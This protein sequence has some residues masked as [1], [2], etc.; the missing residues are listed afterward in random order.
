MKWTPSASSTEWMVTMLGWF[1]A[2]TA[3]ASRSKRGPSFGIGGHLLRQ[4]LERDPALQLGVL[5]NIDLAHS[6]L[7]E[8]ANETVV[9]QCRA[10]H[11]VS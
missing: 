4:H 8:L 7:P 11:G 2:A 6:A 1:K 3:R 5:G 10:D 9:G